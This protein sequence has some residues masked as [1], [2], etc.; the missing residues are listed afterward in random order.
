VA[1]CLWCCGEGIILDT[2]KIETIEAMKRLSSDYLILSLII[3]LSISGGIIVAYAT[4]NGPWG[5]TDPV[6]YISTARSLDNGQGFGYYDGNAVFTPIA[7]HPPFYPL[8]LAFLGVFK[9]NLVV[10][11]RWF[12]TFAFVASIFL[13]GLFFFLYCRVQVLGIIA[14][15]LMVAFPY[16]VE[17]FSSA[18][19]EPLFILLLLSGGLSLIAFLRNEKPFNFLSSVLLFALI[20]MTRYIGFALVIA[21]G[22]SIMLFSTGKARTRIKKAALFVSIASVPIFIWLLWVYSGSAHNLAG[23]S[24]SVNPGDLG[25]RFQTFRGIFLDTVW[26][27]IPFQSHKTLWRYSVRLVLTGLGLVVV[28]VLSLL[29]KRKLGNDSNA[30]IQE[31]GLLILSFFGLSS[32]TGL[33][34][35]TCSYIFAS[36]TLTMDNRMLLPFYVTGVMTLSGGFALWHCAWFR[37]RMQILQS[38]PCLMMVVCV[39]WYFPQTK[40]MISSLHPG[41]GY[42]A[43]RWDRAALIQAVRSLPPDKAVISDEWELLLLWTGRPIYNIWN[44]FPST[45]PVHI[46]MYGTDQHDSTQSLFCEQGA[47]LVIFDDFATNFRIEVGEF[48]LDQVP[49][50]FEGLSVFGDYPDGKIYLCP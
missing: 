1:C 2:G 9:I 42:T 41:V 50:L 21:A 30:G 40:E 12:N 13:A 18:Y 15:A 26:K 31:S 4:A 46:S 23:R 16:M 45:P 37:G 44:T 34:V 33:V 20:P 49:H 3:I 29:A 7:F 5:Y 14:S 25:V 43:F 27:W 10:G 32:L 22:V 48:Y 28:L 38:I 11:A 35:L 8:V 47:A 6:A 39:I 19:S 17:M 36:P 24:I